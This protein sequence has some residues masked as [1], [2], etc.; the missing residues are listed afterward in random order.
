VPPQT[1][2]ERVTVPGTA[3]PIVRLVPPPGQSTVPIRIT[4]NNFPAGSL[5]A[6]RPKAA[7]FGMLQKRVPF[8]YPGVTA[9]VTGA[10][11]G[12]GAGVTIIV[13]PSTP[14]DDTTPSVPSVGVQF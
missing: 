10:T 13:G 5:E 12:A 6:I 1:A 3:Q 4:G 9:D 7:A 2:V 8:G 14:V 11:G